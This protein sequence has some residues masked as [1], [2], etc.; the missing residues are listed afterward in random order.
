MIGLEGV[1][2]LAQQY[3]TAALNDVLPEYVVPEVVLGDV[4]ASVADVG[5]GAA[6]IAAWGLTCWP[7]PA[8]CGGAEL[9]AEGDRV[10][11]GDV[12]EGDRVADAG[13]LG[14][15]EVAV[16]LVGVEDEVAVKVRPGEE[17]GRPPP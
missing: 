14:Q 16:P 8:G 15:R 7:R 5:D 17:R 12:A 13:R 3:T 11:E 6:G 9:V 2:P 1:G 10:A 4:A